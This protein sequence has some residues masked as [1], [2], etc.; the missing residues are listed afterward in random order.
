MNH[1]RLLP[2]IFTTKQTISL[3]KILL[4]DSYK[5]ARI[6]HLHPAY[7]KIDINEVYNELLKDGLSAFKISFQELLDKVKL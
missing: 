2:N 6:K 3:I 5:I 4:K 1:K 7:N